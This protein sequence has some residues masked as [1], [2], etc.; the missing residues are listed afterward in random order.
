MKLATII[1]TA[2]LITTSTCLATELPPR[3][4]PGHT[5][6]S[7]PYLNGVHLMELE[8]G[9]QHGENRLAEDDKGNQFYF[10]HYQSMKLPHLEK[11]SCYWIS[12]EIVEEIATYG[13]F[14]T[15]GFTYYWNTGN[16]KMLPEFFMKGQKDCIASYFKSNE[17][18]NKG[19]VNFAIKD[20]NLVD[21]FNISDMYH[22]FSFSDFD[23]D[24]LF[25]LVCAD[26]SWKD[27]FIEYGFPSSL[28]IFK[29]DESGK[30]TDKTSQFQTVTDKWDNDLEQ[31]ARESFDNHRILACINLALS[32]KNHGKTGFMAKIEEIINDTKGYV[33]GEVPSDAA[34]IVEQL[35]TL[36]NESK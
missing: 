11:I 1:T 34:K 22:P 13:P 8:K 9:W 24:G 4:A 31:F 15:M 32:L 6:P 26:L 35:K 36:T 17:P 10:Q 18:Y 29:P 12:H 20:Y 7:G 19:F 21:Q 30:F 14:P 2:I 25:E 28:Q 3:G 23:K 33:N 27:K 5:Q 16:P